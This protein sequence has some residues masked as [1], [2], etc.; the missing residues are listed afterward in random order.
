MSGVPILEIVDLHAA[1]G[2]IEVLRGVDLQC[3]EGCGD[4]AAGAQRRGQV[5]PGQGHLGAEEADQRGPPPRRGPRAG[6]RFR[7]AGRGSAS[8]R[9][10]RVG[11]CSRTSRCR[12]TSRSCRTPGSR[13]R[14]SWRPRSP[15]SPAARAARPAR[16]DHVRRRAA[17]ARHVAGAGLGPGPAAPRRAL[18]MGLAPLIV[19]ELYDTVAQI[20]ESGVSILCIEQ[21]ARTALR[22]LR[23]RRR[24][25]RR[26]D[27]G[28]RRARR[29]P[30]DHVRRHPRRS[31]M[32]SPVI[33]LLATG[34]VAAVLPWGAAPAHAEEKAVQR[35]QHRRARHAG[36]AGDLRAD[37]PGAGDP[38]SWS[39]PSA[40][41]RSRRLQRWAGRSSFLWPGD[42][43]GEG[44]KTIVERSACRRASARSPPRATRCRST[45]SS[46]PGRRPPPTSRSRPGDADLRGGRRGQ[47]V[48]R[49][50]H[51]LRRVCA[52]E[53]GGGA[54]GI[55]PAVLPSCRACPDWPSCRS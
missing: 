26:L 41:A 38:A 31:S 54:P 10:R 1:Y 40:T 30:R 9:S 33:P 24:H 3:P 27:R 6:R 42:P 18:S 15:T 46:P 43:I 7:G 4:G 23:L 48:R 8:A 14:R 29:G 13:P 39:C 52:G 21:F 37:H 53:P 44:L 49:V 55:G 25:E 35:L 11:R 12:R 2:R 36:Q 16:R 28:Q 19:D 47:R 22:V 51:R 17:D 32:R 34:L 45:P 20:A 50:L 5:H